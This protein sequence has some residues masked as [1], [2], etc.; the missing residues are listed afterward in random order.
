MDDEDRQVNI[1][2]KIKIKL[3]DG[4]INLYLDDI[5]IG[6]L[7]PSDVTFDWFY[8]TIE[9]DDPEKITEMERLFIEKYKNC[10]IDWWEEEYKTTGNFNIYLIDKSKLIKDIKQLMTKH[11]LT[12]DDL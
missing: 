4:R 10:D 8:E 9:P 6:L 3:D 11:N 12:K 2:K 7:H 1:N 5:F